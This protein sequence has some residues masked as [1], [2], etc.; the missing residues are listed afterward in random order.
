MR[1]VCAPDES[2]GPAL[3]DLSGSRL[4]R[5]NPSPNLQVLPSMSARRHSLPILLAI[6]RRI[7]PQQLATLPDLFRNHVA[8]ILIAASRPV[9]RR[10]LLALP[11]Q[12]VRSLLS[13]RAI[14]GSSM[15]M[16]FTVSFTAAR[17]HKVRPA[18]VVH[19][20]PSLV[21]P[22]R[23]S[24]LARRPTPLLHQLH[25]APHVQRA[26]I[27]SPVVRSA[28]ERLRWSALTSRVVRPLVRLRH[29]LR[30]ASMVH[31][32]AAPVKAPRDS[33]LASRIAVLPNQVHIAT[34]VRLA[35]VPPAII[36]RAA[37]NRF[38]AAIFPR[39][40]EL[41]PEVSPA[42]MIH[43]DSAFVISPRIPLHASRAA[44]LLFQRHARS[45]IRRAIAPPAVIRRAG[46]LPPAVGIGRA[47]HRKLRP[48]TVVHPDPPVVVT[49]RPA[50][51]AWRAAHLLHHRYSVARIRLAKLFA[52]VIG[53]AAHNLGPR[54]S[55]KRTQNHTQHNQHSQN[56]HVVL[57]LRRN[58]DHPSPPNLLHGPA[59]LNPFVPCL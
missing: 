2:A 47:P 10:N 46:N 56:S 15:P 36:R 11:F 52:P 5:F 50:L 23:I 7:P 38:A 53:R 16:L 54:G 25:S 40:L 9:P 13:N 21:G 17:C 8:R 51:L 24:F 19:P 27:P 14:T 20:N 26:E 12:F 43:P 48:A 44:G 29:K 22:P 39:P 58:T 34:R 1:V 41:H 59:D 32:D 35:V 55:R 6:P 28:I 49:P 4:D 18:S 45:R 57:R 42:S 31:P 33:L 37:H 30:P 3:F